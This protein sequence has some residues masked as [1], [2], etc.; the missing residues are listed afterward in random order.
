MKVEND[1]EC[2]AWPQRGQLPSTL[3]AMRGEVSADATRLGRGQ[4]QEPSVMR[5]AW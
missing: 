4:R 1:R 2:S 3:G 5:S